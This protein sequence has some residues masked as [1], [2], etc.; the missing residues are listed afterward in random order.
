ESTKL[1]PKCNPH[2]PESTKSQQIKVLA[3][4]TGLK[5]PTSQ[6]PEGSKIFKE[7]SGLLRGG[8]CFIGD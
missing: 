3:H 7:S 5:F 8:Q 6:K 1:A 2:R 4:L